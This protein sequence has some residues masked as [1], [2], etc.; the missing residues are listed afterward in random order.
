LNVGSSNHERRIGEITEEDW[1]EKKRSRRSGKVHQ[2]SKHRNRKIIENW[3]V[4]NLG[5]P[6]TKASTAPKARTFGRGTEKR[7]DRAQQKKV[8]WFIGG[9]WKLGNP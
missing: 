9:N 3:K 7:L 8:V 6:R 5:V 2:S 4:R 1:T